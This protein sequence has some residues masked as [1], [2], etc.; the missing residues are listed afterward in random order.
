MGGDGEQKG[1]DG[2]GDGVAARPSDLVLFAKAVTA[3][4]QAWPGRVKVLAEGNDAARVDETLAFQRSALPGI[5]DWATHHLDTEHAW[6]VREQMLLL[7]LGVVRRSD[8]IGGGGA[9]GEK[10]VG[11]GPSSPMRQMMGG[12]VK[13]LKDPKYARVRAAALECIDLILA[14]LLAR[15]EADPSHGLDKGLDAALLAE[16]VGHCLRLANDAAFEVASAASRVLAKTRRCIA[17]RAA[18]GG[19]AASSAGCVGGDM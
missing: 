2:G 14:K 16:L 19:A 4:G 15:L 5:I 1:G 7:L 18:V 3:L 8:G 12:A 9:G 11:E 10:G 13:Q 6:N 17:A